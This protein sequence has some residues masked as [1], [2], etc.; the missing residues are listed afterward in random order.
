[1]SKAGQLG[2]YVKNSELK[3]LLK[4][5]IHSVL[6]DA[7]WQQDQKIDLDEFRKC[8]VYILYLYYFSNPL[9]QNNSN[10]QCLNIF[11]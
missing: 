2:Q 4:E 1:M 5:I 11:G 8:A 3:S 7:D 10:L 6:L 9:Q